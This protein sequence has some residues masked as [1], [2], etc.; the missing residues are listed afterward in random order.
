[1]PPSMLIKSFYI[2][3]FQNKNILEIKKET[4]LK[5]EGAL[6]KNTLLNFLQK[7]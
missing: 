4:F 1:M 7:R 5:S 3:Q 6:I 2:L